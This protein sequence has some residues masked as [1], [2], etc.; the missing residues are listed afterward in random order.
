MVGLSN[1]SAPEAKL[2]LVSEGADQLLTFGLK[3]QLSINTLHEFALQSSDVI[4]F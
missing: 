3:F 4:W 2:E 1:L